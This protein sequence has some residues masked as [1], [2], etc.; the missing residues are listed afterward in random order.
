MSEQQYAEN[1]D[2]DNTGARLCP[3]GD[4]QAG[5]DQCRRIAA[6]HPAWPENRSVLRQPED[7]RDDRNRNAGD[8]AALK[9]SAVI[10]DQ[11]DERA[12]ATAPSCG[13][14]PASNNQRRCA[15]HHRQHQ[16][17]DPQLLMQR[18]RQ[19]GGEDQCFPYPIPLFKRGHRFGCD[20]RRISAIREQ[21]EQQNPAR[22]NA[23][24]LLVV[25]DQKSQ[26]RQSKHYERQRYRI[27]QEIAQPLRRYDVDIRVNQREQKRPLER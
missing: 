13:L 11:D 14:D 1:G 4:Q 19:E 18:E 26:E 24:I 17:F 23:H 16:C 12:V 6:N 20:R 7:Q 3:D 10:V 25:T 21:H 8:N 27:E 15:K 22:C 2:A 9:Q 5:K